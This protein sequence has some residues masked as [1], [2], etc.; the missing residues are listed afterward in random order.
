[1]GAGYSKVF[2]K[3]RFWCCTGTGIENFTKLGDSI[4]FKNNERIYVNMYFSS[5]LKDTERNISVKQEANLPNSEQIKLTI[6]AID[7]S[8][9]ANGT[10]LYLRVPQ[11][12]AGQ[13]SVKINDNALASF[14]VL[15]G[16]IVIKDVKKDDVIELNFPMEVAVNSLK[17]NE[18]IVAFTYG[19]VVLAARLGKNNIGQSESTGVMVLHAV[20]DLL[21]PTSILLKNDTAIEWKKNIKENLVRIKDTDE[22]FIQFRAKGT[23]LNEEITFT[24]YY[25]MFDYRYGLYMNIDSKDSPEMI[26][27]ILSDKEELR[28]VEAAS[29]SLTQFDG[30]NYEATYNMQKSENSSVGEY[31]GRSYREAQKNGWF[32]YDMPIVEGV[33]NYLNTVY[34]KAD[35]QRSFKILINDEDFVTETITNTKP[36]TSDGFYT[37]KREIPIKYTKGAGVLYKEIAG[38]LT[39]CINIKFQSTGGLVGGLYG[40]S[41]THGFDN[42]PNLSGLSFDVGTMSP[43]FNA[44]TKEYTLIVP[45]DTQS[46][47]LK[48]TPTKRSGLVYDGDILI[49]D[50]QLREINLSSQNTTLKLKTYA[51][52]HETSTVYTVHIILDKNE[53]QNDWDLVKMEKV[54]E[55]NGIKFNAVIHNNNSEKTSIMGVLAIYNA[56]GCLINSSTVR[57]NISKGGDGE[58][59]FMLGNK[60]LGE[61]ATLYFW[62]D[63]NY[64][65]ILEKIDISSYL[66]EN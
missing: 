8:D 40:L 4:Y 36:S 63:D 12:C 52:D 45:G 62:H 18:N 48:A 54:E 9:V 27:K 29:G 47:N 28:N 56:D 41:I 23:Y 66:W 64:V 59:G 1:M 7:G 55:N 22:G 14:E 26:A 53:S 15:G 57:K 19:P 21:L 13:P 11:W 5:L 3:E 44:D 35:N 50:T 30:N 24:P 10:I 2:N 33:Q 38:V 46:V 43:A 51:Q 34:T 61:K 39:P 20:Q 60:V 58:F 32:S 42:N 17:D 65:P 49:D 6:D 37:E 25:T 16:Y 31:N